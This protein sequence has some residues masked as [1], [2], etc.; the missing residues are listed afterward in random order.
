MHGQHLQ[1]WVTPRK[2]EVAFIVR[3]SGTFRGLHR[4]D[5]VKVLTRAGS[6]LQESQV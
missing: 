6:R 2:R 5:L 4:A 1:W 3:R